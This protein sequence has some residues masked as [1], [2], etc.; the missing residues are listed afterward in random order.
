[1]IANE[2]IPR[3]EMYSQT[4]HASNAQAAELMSAET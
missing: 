4:I 3:Q 1:M 2:A